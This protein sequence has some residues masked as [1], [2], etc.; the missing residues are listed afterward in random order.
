MIINKISSNFC[1]CKDYD[2]KNNP[3]NHDEGCNRCIESSLKDR[4]IPFCFFNTISKVDA[5]KVKDFSYKG[6]A[7]FVISHK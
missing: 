2:C 6:F 7:E 5:E 1:T 4:E 3:K